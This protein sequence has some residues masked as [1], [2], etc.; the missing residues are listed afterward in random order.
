MRL[1]L[2][3]LLAIAI[4]GTWTLAGP[5]V[6]SG[7]WTL[8]EES[9]GT[10]AVGTGEGERLPGGVGVAPGAIE[11]QPINKQTEEEFD[12]DPP[13]RQAKEKAEREAAK[14]AATPAPTEGKTAAAS[15]VQCVVP[16]LKGESLA[17]ARHSLNAAHCALGKIT[18]PHK[19]RGALV[20][21]SQGQ[22]AG[23]TLANETPIA[24]TLGSIPKHRHG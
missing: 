18:R 13:W 11:P 17:A 14:Q 15:P 10:S 2:T 21:E 1:K 5:I 12:R 16:S 24:I 3:A 22:V 4:V 19:H 9:G 23:K 7:A 20:V 8:N 6:S